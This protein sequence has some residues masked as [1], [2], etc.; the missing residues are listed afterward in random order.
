[1]AAMTSS[2]NTPLAR[3]MTPSCHFA[4]RKENSFGHNVYLLGAEVTME[5]K[6]GPC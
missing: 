3:H 1:M 4:D 5:H 6:K 2:A